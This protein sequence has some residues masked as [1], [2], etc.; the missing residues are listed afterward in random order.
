MI[1][2]K[3][4]YRFI[5][6]PSRFVIKKQTNYNFAVFLFDDLTN[7]FILFEDLLK[8]LDAQVSWRFRI[9]AIFSDAVE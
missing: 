3:L 2:N 7:I 1:A 5:W 8:F 4:E 9:V 6:K